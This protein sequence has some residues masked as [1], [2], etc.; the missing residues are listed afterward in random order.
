MDTLKNLIAGADPLGLAIYLGVMVFFLGTIALAR[1]RDEVMASRKA[2]RW[3]D[4]REPIASKTG[5]RLSSIPSGEA[6]PT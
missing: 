5:P 1:L 3:D 6:G 2:R 4:R